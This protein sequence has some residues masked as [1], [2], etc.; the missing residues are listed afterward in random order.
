MGLYDSS[1]LPDLLRNLQQYSA[2]R[3]SATGRGLT[4]GEIRAATEGYQNAESARRLDIQKQSM[5]NANQARMHN[6]SAVMQQKQLDQQDNMATAKGIMSIPKMGLDAYAM[7]KY[8][9][10]PDPNVPGSVAGSAGNLKPDQA[11]RAGMP[12]Y[13][14][15][16]TAAP[17]QVLSETAPVISDSVSTVDDFFPGQ[18]TLSSVEP[19]ASG[20]VLTGLPSSITGGVGGTV[21]SLAG[22]YLSDE[23]GVKGAGPALSAAGS[24]LATGL[25]TGNYWNPVGWA[26]AGREFLGDK[27]L[28]VLQGDMGT[29]LAGTWDKYNTNVLTDPKSNLEYNAWLANGGMIGWGSN[30]EWDP[31]SDVTD[32][33]F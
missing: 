32:S 9:S 3:R 22:N 12:S 31:F 16:A 20:G 25:A 15:N 4:P 33:I 24:T 8:F 26:I 17:S 27:G 30:P 21:G 10:K 2:A 6:Q 23:Y 19:T 1:Y 7:Y 5:N 29:D 14:G 13:S 11:P 28:G 18:S